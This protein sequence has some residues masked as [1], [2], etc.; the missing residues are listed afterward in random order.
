M[1]RSW[2][3]RTVGAIATLPQHDDPAAAE[4]PAVAVVT[5]AFHSE[6]VLPSLARDLGVQSH[7]PKVWVVVDNSPLTAPL[8]LEALQVA[9]SGAGSGRRGEEVE[10][11]GAGAGLAIRLLAGEEGDGFGAGC[12]RA[13]Q[14]LEAAHWQGWVWLLNPDTALPRGQ[15]L[16][17]LQ[18]QLA[19]LPAQA[20]VGTAVDDGEGGFEASGGWIDRGFDFRGRKL[21][22]GQIRGTDPVAVDWLSGCSL[23]LRP[24]AHSPAAR[25]DPRFPLYYEDMDLCL[26]LAR[27]GAPVLWLPSPC[28][29]HRRGT[30]SSTPEP[31]RWR[32]STESYLRFLRRHCSGWVVGL[33]SLRLLLLSLLRLPFRPRRSLAVL[34]AMT[35]VLSEPP[36]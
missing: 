3:E 18:Q 17:Q 11:E 5:V 6:R 34:A 12:N 14:A 26:R 24:T 19:S 2:G 13:L 23:V 21:E 25:F 32:L 15:E 20:L 33:R 36:R 1:L 28:V 8:R 16:E 9:A 31:R 35:D 29:G 22:A 10:V 4:A 27:Q 30:G 7:T